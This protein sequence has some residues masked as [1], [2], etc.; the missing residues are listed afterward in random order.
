MPRLVSPILLVMAGLV[1]AIPMRKGSA[2]HRV[3]ITGTGPVMTGGVYGQDRLPG[4]TP[5]PRARMDRSP[6]F[7]FHAH[8]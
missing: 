4:M 6:A 1:P 3:G 2:L 7:P 5:S 8:A